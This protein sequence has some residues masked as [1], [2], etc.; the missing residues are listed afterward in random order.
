MRL[1]IAGRY[2][3]RHRI[4]AVLQLANLDAI[5]TA[6]WLDGPQRDDG[7]LMHCQA[8]A[9][10]R[11]NWH[12]VA[13]C[14]ALLFFPSWTVSCG[15]YVDLGMALALQ[16]PVIVV[17]SSGQDLFRHSI[18]LRPTVLRYAELEDLEQAIQDVNENHSRRGGYAASDQD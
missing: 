6:A 4:K 8:L 3:E 18:Y 7:D 13:N 12:E 14:D 17:G 1:A 11:C 2:A 10:V 5:V 9:Q 15:R 16:K